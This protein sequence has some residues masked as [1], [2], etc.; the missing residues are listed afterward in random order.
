MAENMAVGLTAAQDSGAGPDA[1]TVSA[2]RQRVAPG[3]I[4][5]PWLCA[6]PFYEDV[7]ASVQGLTLF[8]RPGASV[9][10]MAM[11]EIVAEAAPLLAGTP[12]EGDAMRFRGHSGT[13]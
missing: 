7:S 5:K 11:A 2:F 4:V 6:G 10:A 8:E 9:G 13:W 3:Q 1:E 12:R